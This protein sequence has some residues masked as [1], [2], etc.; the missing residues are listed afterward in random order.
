MIV[1]GRRDEVVASGRRD[2]VICSASASHDVIYDN[3]SDS[4]GASCRRHHDQVLPVRQLHALAVQASVANISGNGSTEDPFVA[5]CAHPQNPDCS[6]TAFP[7][8]SLTGLWANEYV[9]AYRCPDDHPFLLNQN[10]APLGTHLPPGVEIQQ[11]QRGVPGDPWQ[12]GVTIVGASVSDTHPF[13]TGTKTGSRTRA[14]RIGIRAP[15]ATGSSS[16]AQRSGVGLPLRATVLGS[17]AARPPWPMA[18]STR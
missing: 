8:R 7:G 2:H 9:P 6:V 16:I 5:P 18:R 10:Y 12:I 17:T 13:L 14:P 11:S 4:I 1:R 3:S 15:A